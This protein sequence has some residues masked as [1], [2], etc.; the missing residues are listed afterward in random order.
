HMRTEVKAE[1]EAAAPAIVNDTS[2]AASLTTEQMS[3]VMGG[4][5]ILG[6]ST[7]GLEMRRYP[8]DCQQHLSPWREGEGIPTLDQLEKVRCHEIS[9]SGISFFWPD[10]PDF[11]EVVVSIGTGDKLI[12]MQAELSQHKAVCMHREV[13]F[14]VSC[15]Y[16]RRLDELTAQ[17]HAEEGLA[18]VG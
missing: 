1:P 15:K 6:D 3:D 14:L 9:V 2:P 16:L 17:W 8:Y 7:L 11:E 5:K 18:I 10:E 12:F 13:Q 4:R